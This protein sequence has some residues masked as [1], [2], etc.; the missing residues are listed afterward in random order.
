MSFIISAMQEQNYLL[1][2]TE[3]KLVPQL[4]YFF[5]NESLQKW[6][7]PILNFAAPT[8]ILCVMLTHGWHWEASTRRLEGACAIFTMANWTLDLNIV[9]LAKKYIHSSKLNKRCNPC[10]HSSEFCTHWWVSGHGWVCDY[11]LLWAVIQ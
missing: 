10:T 2:L 7:W 11:G 5:L 1:S 4:V 9:K 6:T 3:A 8:F